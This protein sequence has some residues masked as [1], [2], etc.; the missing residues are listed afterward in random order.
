MSDVTK[1]W[2]V[3]SDN[4]R[5]SHAEMSGETVD[6]NDTFSNG[7]RFP[8]DASTGDAAEV[9]NCSC[10][11]S[12]EGTVI[13]TEEARWTDEFSVATEFD[14]LRAREAL[15]KY[16]QT[17]G[18]PIADIQK[19]IDDTASGLIE[20]A[21][22]H[23]EFVSGV[24]QKLETQFS[25]ANLGGF[26]PPHDFHLKSE[27]SLRGKLLRDG[28]DNDFAL[29]PEAAGSEIRDVLR[30]TFNLEGDAYTDGVTAL[31]E[32]MASDD[33]VELKWKNS[34]DDDIYRGLNTQFGTSDGFEFEVQFH[35]PESFALKNGPLHT[36]Y[37]QY[38]VL[39][40]AS[41]EARALLAETKK[42]TTAL[43]QPEGWETLVEK[44]RA[45]EKATFEGRP[46]LA[47]FTPELQEKFLTI[48]NKLEKGMREV[49]KAESRWNGRIAVGDKAVA[50]GVGD[51]II[52]EGAAGA[53]MDWDGV[54]AM[55][56][57][58]AWF[59]A[60]GGE[61]ATRMLLHELAH[62]FSPVD[63]KA[64]TLNR[65]AEEGVAEGFAR[66][67]AAQVLGDKFA[68][69]SE[70]YNVYVSQF[71]AARVKAGVRNRLLW[72]TKLLRMTSDERVALIRSLG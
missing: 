36:L 47:P 62:S 39:D 11:M 65:A 1:T 5:A 9:A 52:G 63:A 48:T 44:F 12:I 51:A 27:S 34:W 69:S 40:E 67:Y 15:V 49:I 57:S 23:D 68:W 22:S 72:Y 66:S 71:E 53:V 61:E 55:G 17:Q 46:K 70:V 42:L 3:T 24:M 43:D 21:K 29:S 2:E 32:A 33:L 10:V 50:R 58:P 7:L 4:P 8:G 20:R 38:R 6:I 28:L 64:Y 30:Y 45:V 37:N 54:M 13:G 18:V 60:N 26:H 31:R 19:A 56:D 16:S 41:A 59:I 35:T 14:P 25:D